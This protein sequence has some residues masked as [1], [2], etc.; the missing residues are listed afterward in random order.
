[1]NNPTLFVF[2]VFLWSAVISAV[3]KYGG[4]LLAI[5]P[6]LQNAAIAVALPPIVLAIALL[7]QLRQA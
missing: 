6:T 7:W 1:M 3:I 2:K 4:P 5:A